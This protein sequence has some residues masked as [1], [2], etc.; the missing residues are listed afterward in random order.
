V[1]IVTLI[2]RLIRGGA[3]RIALETAAELTRRGHEAPLWCG[4]ETGPEG[5]LREE[6]EAR[7]VR[8]RLFPHLRR[9]VDPVHDLRAFLELRRA[10]RKERPD[11]LHT[12]SSKAGILGREAGVA[13]GV[14][15]LAHTVHGWGFT[16]QSPPL[17]RALFVALERREAARCARGAD[18][19]LVFVAR[20]DREEGVRLGILPAG[21]GI[22]IPPGIDLEPYRD[23][24]ALAGARARRRA[25]C[26][27]DE[28]HLVGGFLGRLSPQKDPATLLE[29]AALLA[30][31][32]PRLRWLVVGDGPLAPVLRAR[33][34]ADARLGQRISF[35]GLQAEASPWLAAMDFLLLPS[36]WEG[37]PLTVMEAM[38]AGTPL[39]ASD[40]PGVRELLAP[41]SD[42][43]GLL[44]A[45]GDAASFAASVRTLIG[46]PAQARRR[47]GSARLRALEGFGR[48]R[49]LERIVAL[50]EA[51]PQS[52][53]QL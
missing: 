30:D 3:Q 43:L 49:M 7:G 40:L 39:V 8:V 32:L 25:D 13:A 4:P 41:A 11:W 48:E 10:L 2:T 50:Y 51:P 22:V 38:A 52:T 37:T 12:H 21:A 5:S 34:A 14:P 45:P 1:K 6:A 47:A 29:T 9:A 44:A 35:R 23:A 31:E 18:R 20:S 53:N 24:A 17:I 46:E 19:R 28:G 42:P 26:G 16:P 33:V 27:W 36:L 15:G